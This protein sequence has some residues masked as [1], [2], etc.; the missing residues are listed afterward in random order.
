MAFFWALRCSLRLPEILGAEV[1]DARDD[2]WRD[3]FAMWLYM[4][5]LVMGHSP[6]ET[7]PVDV[8]DELVA[9]FWRL[10]ELCSRLEGPVVRIC[11]L[12]LGLLPDKAQ[13][14]NHLGEATGHLEEDPAAQ[15]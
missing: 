8:T 13:W 9:Q 14:A 15:R 1:G 6:N 2:F 12:L 4:T 10:K 11:H 5:E 3:S 7:F